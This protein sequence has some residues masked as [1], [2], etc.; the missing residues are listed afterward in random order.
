VLP[1]HGLRPGPVVPSVIVRERL[2][3]RYGV[4][5]LSLPVWITHAVVDGNAARALELFLVPA[6]ALPV[7]G[8]LAAEERELNLQ[9]HFAF[10]TDSPDEST[11]VELH[12]MLT[13]DGVMDCDGGGINTYENVSA[14][15]FKRPGRLGRWPCRLELVVGGSYPELI[16]THLAGGL[17]S[18]DSSRAFT[19]APLVEI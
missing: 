12:R 1:R 2:A 19:L 13:G 4:D 17:R 10:A 16:K 6:G 8:V 9:S 5:P 18:A 15:Y 11:L 3:A 7:G 14:F